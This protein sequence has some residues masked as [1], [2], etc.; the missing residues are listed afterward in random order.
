LTSARIEDSFHFSRRLIH[1]PLALA[2]DAFDD[3]NDH[4]DRPQTHASFSGHGIPSFYTNNALPSTA[5]SFEV[6]AGRLP[7]EGEAT[8]QVARIDSRVTPFVP[9]LRAFFLSIIP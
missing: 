8:F 9:L 7:P 5:L 6:S 3:E 1:P 4:D 2:R